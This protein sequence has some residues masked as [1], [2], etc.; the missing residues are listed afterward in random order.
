MSILLESEIISQ[1]ITVTFPPSVTNDQQTV[2]VPF[3]PDDILEFLEEGFFLSVTV[4]GA[5]DDIDETM[6]DPIRGGVALLII[7]DDD[8]KPLDQ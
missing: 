1:T 5:S 8:G 6:S 2:P 7:E 3:V 4:D